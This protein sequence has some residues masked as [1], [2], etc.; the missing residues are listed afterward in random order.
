M[1]LG[2]SCVHRFEIQNGKVSYRN[3]ET[4]TDIEARAKETGKFF[5]FGMSLVTSQSKLLTTKAYIF[6]RQVKMTPNQ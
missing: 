3:K 6:H 5:G 4:S 1:T 2:G